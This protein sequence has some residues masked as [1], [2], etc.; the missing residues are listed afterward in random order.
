VE[1]AKAGGTGHL[2]G[3]AKTMGGTARWWDVQ[4][5]AMPGAGGLPAKLLCVSRDIT[6]H[7]QG[8]IRRMALLEVGDRLRDLQNP[9][10]MAF[11]AA[12]IMG[13]TLSVG[14][15]GYGMVDPAAET[16]TI[17]RDWTMPGVASIAGAH[18]FRAFGGFIEA[19]K[20]GAMVVFND[21]EQEHRTEAGIA[22]FQATGARAAINLP[23]FEHG[24]LVALFYL[25]HPEPRAWS[26]QDLVFVRNV[27]DRV[28]VAIGRLRAEQR[29]R[30]LAASLEKQVEERT[31]DRNRLWQLSSDIMIV[32]RT[33]GTIAAVNPAWTAVLGW[34][35]QDFIGVDVFDLIHPDDL[36]KT[37]EARRQLADGRSLTRFDNR[38]RHKDGSYRWIAWAA[39][40]G[41]G[42]LNAVGRDFTAE[43]QQREALERSK[44]RLR[45]VFETS[46]QY[47]GLLTPEGILLDANPAS[48]AGIEARLEDVVGQPFWDTPWFTATP[49][50]PEQVKAAIPVVALGQGVRQEIT[51]VLP[52]GCGIF[53]FSMRP[54][55]NAAR[56][57]IA[58]VPEAIDLTQ[59][60]QAE[61]Q[62]RQS[63][64]MEAVGQLTGGIAHDFNNLLTGIT[65]S[66]ELLQTRLAKGRLDSAA[67]F[68][69]AALGAAG[70]A[71]ALTHRLLA[72]SR[73]QTLDPKP[74]QANRLIAEMEELVRRTVGPAV[75]VQTVMAPGLWTTLCDPNQLENALLNLC[76]NARDAM[77]DGGRLIIETANIAIEEPD[78]R[79]REMMPGSY[80]AICVT[81]TGT[82]MA[83]DVAARAFDPFFT[84]KPLGQGTG[85]GLSMIYGFVR[86]S[87]GYVR[88]ESESGAGTSMWLYLPRFQGTAEAMPAGA[89][90]AAAPRAEAGE[91][92]LIV[93]DEPTVRM[94]V[95]EV[96]E[97]LGYA[98][99]E[100]G[101]GASGLAVLRSEARIDLVITDVGLPGGMNGRQLAD[102]ARQL[103]PALKVLFITGYAENAVAANGQLEPG[104]HVLTK[105]F[106]ME[107]LASRIK[108]II[109]DE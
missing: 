2:Q 68:I 87:G 13:R 49:G 39:V 89:E 25:R 94:L 52:K 66:L 74:T 108:A 16:V 40:P 59:R 69:T 62:L 107:A 86:Q 12:E 78:A 105:P 99:I 36:D 4:V 81:D 80:V 64:K 42:M 17:G 23:I 84:T 53:D 90:L 103:R 56:E 8:E 45:S 31:A 30:E 73:R 102:T 70:R 75:A 57:V 1:T 44:A 37:N 24:A 21:T 28:R 33:D 47:Q 10:E 50:M 71:A 7:K 55:F 41:G 18:R 95:T 92:V 35:E 9:D 97:E 98:A 34:A 77:P 3:M 38:L 46:Y 104:M 76:I 101:D 106:A 60:R 48:L 83:A 14:G 5:T 93:D 15:A 32:I 85:L 79:A 82:G 91:T 20:Q 96:L 72:F 54:V 65:G 29:L 6:D 109:A 100:A 51:V 11:V 22:A 27:A 67:H 26:R 61:E 88:I 58:I 19:L 43:K 63:Q